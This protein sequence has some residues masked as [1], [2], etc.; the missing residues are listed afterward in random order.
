MSARPLVSSASRAAIRGVRPLTRTQLGLGAAL[1]SINPLGEPN[2]YILRQYIIGLGR[3]PTTG[4]R[5]LSSSVSLLNKKDVTT[6][7]GKGASQPHSRPG[8]PQTSAP[9]QDDYKIS[10][11]DLGMTRITKFVVYTV[12]GIL[13]TMETIFWCKALWRWWAGGEEDN[14]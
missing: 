12:I 11:Q 8:N 14:E 6:N 1:L 3:S 10:F 2:V 4:A 13:G 9:S 5:L 7:T